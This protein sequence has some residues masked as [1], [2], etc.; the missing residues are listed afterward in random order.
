MKWTPCVVG[1]ANR[2]RWGTKQP[3]AN[4][5]RPR[6][7]CS[8]FFAFIAVF[9]LVRRMRASATAYSRS[10]SNI[11]VSVSTP[12]KKNNAICKG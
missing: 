11:P 8:S 3:Y 12:E 1:N 2:V 5:D 4:F 9:Y 7:I 10:A 6:I